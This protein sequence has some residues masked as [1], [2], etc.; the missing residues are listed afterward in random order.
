MQ[1]SPSDDTEMMNLIIYHHLLCRL[2][3][4][5]IFHC[6]STCRAGI[7]YL[8]K[9]NKEGAASQWGHVHGYSPGTLRSLIPGPTLDGLPRL[10]Q[11]ENICT[12]SRDQCLLRAG[13]SQVSQSSFVWGLPPCGAP[14]VY[15]M[16]QC[17]CSVSEV[18]SRS[19]FWSSV[20]PLG[21]SL[22]VIIKSM[23]RYKT[24]DLFL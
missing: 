17:L 13:N 6:T 7:P 12:G 19:G 23:T 20:F 18:N 15:G 11:K 21:W 22:I 2:S 8:P 4:I 10:A 1:T 3:Q 5:F 16:Y 24:H 14:C 9:W